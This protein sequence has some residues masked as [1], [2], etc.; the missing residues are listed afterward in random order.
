M[1]L[2]L[3]KPPELPISIS[4]KI[5]SLFILRDHG[6]KPSNRGKYYEKDYF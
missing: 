4:N 5:K 1:K 6:E 3:K 2:S